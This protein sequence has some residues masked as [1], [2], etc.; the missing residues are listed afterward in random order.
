MAE[1]KKITEAELLEVQSMNNAFN[2]LKLKIADSEMTKDHLMGEVK[3]LKESYKAV[4]EKLTEKYGE[5]SVIDIQTG[6]IS[7]K[8]KE[9]EKLEK[10]E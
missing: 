3:K 7:E 6:E 2:Q 1:A 4:E 9:K 8:E 10:V 5:N